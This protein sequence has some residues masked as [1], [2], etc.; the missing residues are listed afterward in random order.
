MREV[1]QQHD[2]SRSVL[3]AVHDAQ[4]KHHAYLEELAGEGAEQRHSED[5]LKSFEKGAPVA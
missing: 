2:V 5:R 4:D 1:E 3:E